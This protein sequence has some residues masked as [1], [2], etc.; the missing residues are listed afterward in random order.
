MSYIEQISYLKGIRSEVPNQELAKGL[1]IANDVAGMDEIASYLFDKNKSIASDCLKVLY[2]AGYINPQLSSNYIDQYLKLLTS[3]NNRMVWGAMIAIWNVAK[4]EHE[5]V[6][7]HIDKILHLTETGTL[8]THVTGIKILLALCEVKTS[9]YDKLYPVLIK[10]LEACR[11]IDFGKRVEDY[12][13]ILNEDN[14]DAIVKI[15]SDRLEH[16][17]KSQL[18]RVKRALKSKGI[19]L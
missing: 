17:N 7:A 16:L 1:A 5:K 15:V 3:K 19:E 8:I 12:M 18:A 4:I 9:Y 10:Y 11:P 13:V 14:K 6:Y 2:E